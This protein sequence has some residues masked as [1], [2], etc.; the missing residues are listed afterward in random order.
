MTGGN[1]TCD[2][3][4]VL[5]GD[6]CSSLCSVENAYFCLSSPSLCYPCL[7]YCLNCADN[8]SCTSCNSLTLWNS[9]SLSC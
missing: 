3:G 9:S 8:S 6:G 4:N 2:D 5:D 1:E 7:Q